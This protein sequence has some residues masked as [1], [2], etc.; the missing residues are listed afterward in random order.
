VLGELRPRVCDDEK[1]VGV[2]FDYRKRGTGREWENLI[3]GGGFNIVRKSTPE[4]AMAVFR[5]LER[6]Q[7]I[8]KF[9]PCEN[10]DHGGKNRSQED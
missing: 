8:F 2:R 3:V 1:W 5:Q 10:L 6:H 7:P 4:D 9:G